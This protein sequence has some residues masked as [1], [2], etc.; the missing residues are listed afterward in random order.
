MCLLSFP[1]AIPSLIRKWLHEGLPHKWR[2]IVEIWGDLLAVVDGQLGES[3][4]RQENME[5]RASAASTVK[6]TKSA[7]HATGC[8][9]LAEETVQPTATVTS[10][11]EREVTELSTSSDENDSRNEGTST[12]FHNLELH[13]KNGGPRNFSKQT[14]NTA[15]R[16]Q[17]IIETFKFVRS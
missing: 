16:L 8:D 5:P 1:T 15:Q 7:D 11:N 6:H 9:E 14:V 3:E 4:L 10:L 17:F 13:M 2:K 12:E